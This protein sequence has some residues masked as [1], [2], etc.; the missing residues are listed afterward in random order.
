MKAK[1]V[2]LPGSKR[3][4]NPKAIRIGATDPKEQVEVT[5][6]LRGPKLPSADE[7]PSKTLTNAELDSKFDASKED[8]DRV[9]K[10]LTKFGLKV[11]QVSLA[12]RS[13]RVSGTAGAMEAAFQPK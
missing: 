2:I 1:H 13:M 9:A 11:D 6:G 5:I 10:S 4:K 3:S 8:A 12:T 7:V